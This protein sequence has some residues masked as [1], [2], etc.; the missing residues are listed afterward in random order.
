[1][2]KKM[3]LGI[4]VDLVKLDRFK[5]MSPTHRDRL[6]ARILLPIEFNTYSKS[7]S[8]S[9][10]LAKYWAAKEAV[11]KSFGTGIRG[12]VVWKNIL[13]KNTELGQPVIELKNEL[14]S[15]NNI[16]HISISHDNGM[17]IAYAILEKT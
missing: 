4:G 3:I 13:L 10:T 15:N 14:S 17:V 12:K 9:T 6:A 1:M 7:K 16:C 8:Q 2:E 5:M 11:S